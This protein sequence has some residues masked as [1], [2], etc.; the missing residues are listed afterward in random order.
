MQIYLLLKLMGSIFNSTLQIID[1][2]IFM[3]LQRV[4]SIVICAT[5]E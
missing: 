5:I 4:I 2:E 1:G 3:M